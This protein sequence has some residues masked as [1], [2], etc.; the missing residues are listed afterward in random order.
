[1]RVAM[2]VVGGG[3]KVTKKLSFRSAFGSIDEDE[4]DD[5][6]EE[7]ACGILELIP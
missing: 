2:K 3:E 5:N 1:M 4:D 7:K 6:D